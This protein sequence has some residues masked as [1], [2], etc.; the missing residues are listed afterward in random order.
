MKK[1]FTLSAVIFTFFVLS[2]T[3][4][5]ADVTADSTPDEPFPDMNYNVY[6][7]LTDS[8]SE[9]V[10]AYK[11][12]PAYDVNGD[13]KVSVT[14]AKSVL[15]HIAEISVLT[16]EQIQTADIDR[17]GKISTVDAKMIL[18]TVADILEIYAS[19]DGVMLDGSYTDA[20]SNAYYFDD[21]FM[22]KGITEIEGRQYL[23]SQ[24]GIMLNEGLHNVFGVNYL[25]LRDKTV[26]LNG[27]YSYNGK[28]YLADANGELAKGRKT[29]D[30]KTYLFGSDCALVVNSS[31]K[32]GGVLYYTDSNGVLL[33]GKVKRADGTYLYENGRPFNGWKYPGLDMFYYDKNGKLAVNTTIGDFKFD[34]NGNPSASVI[35]HN[36]LKYHLRKIL[37]QHGSDARS[38]FDY[39]TNHS[40]FSYKVMNK[41]ASAEEMVIYMLKYHK[42]SCYQFAYFTQ[43]LYREAGFECE[44]VIGTVMST[45]SGTRSTHYWNK[46]KFPDG[47]YYVD[48][49]YPWKYGGIYK[50]TAAEI[51]A[52]SYRW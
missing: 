2:V 29:Y 3:A 1:L 38:I 32:D 25:V 11:V 47:W 9:S 31:A 49:E 30:G 20:D 7:E 28:K 22:A 36:T 16:D 35:N 6:L 17:N 45:V 13:G 44:V 27:F 37:K 4:F 43:A 40:V 26:A 34:A 18:Q 48:T 8:K 39:I 46:V 5:A 50:K 15:K 33:N 24:S 42:G 51:L 10:T 12:I 52:L 41:G 19:E 21:G 23:F 14:D